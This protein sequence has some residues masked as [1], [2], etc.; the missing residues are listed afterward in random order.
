MA[1]ADV[2]LMADAD[3]ELMADADIDIG[4]MVC[5]LMACWL[6]CAG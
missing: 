2:E 1:D 5:R 4:L 6:R 3:V